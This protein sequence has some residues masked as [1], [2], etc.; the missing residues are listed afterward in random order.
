[1]RISPASIGGK[2]QGAVTVAAA[3]GGSAIAASQN[4]CVALPRDLHEHRLRTVQR[5]LRSSEGRPCNRGR[6]ALQ[7]T[8]NLQA[9]RPYRSHCRTPCFQRGFTSEQVM[10]PPRFDQQ[11]GL[12][13]AG[14]PRQN[15]TAAFLS[16]ARGQHLAGVDIGF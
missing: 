9:K 12:C 1:M 16:R 11:L 13:A 10:R 3:C 15:Q 14:M 7:I 6:S 8:R 4:W 2:A 5:T